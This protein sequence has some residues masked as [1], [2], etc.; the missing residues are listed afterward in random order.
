MTEPN[1]QV[2]EGDV[3]QPGQKIPISGIYEC[4]SDCRHSWSTDPKDHR[5]PPMKDG[6][7]GHGWKLMAKAPSGT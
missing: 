2:N 4:D 7:S 5:F 1:P 3:F 6:C